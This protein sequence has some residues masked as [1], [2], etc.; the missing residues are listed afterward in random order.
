MLIGI[1][2]TQNISKCVCLDIN[3]FMEKLLEEKNE[4]DEE[5]EQQMILE[6]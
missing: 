3:K 6:N 4:D 2:K 1:Y 5:E